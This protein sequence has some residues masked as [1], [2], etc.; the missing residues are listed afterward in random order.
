VSTG[1]APDWRDDALCRRSP[2]LQTFFPLGTTAPAR[3]TT[4]RAKTFCG[5][6]PV[7]Q[8][9]AQWALT[10]NMEFGVWGGLDEDERRSIR[11][12][13]RELLAN[14]KELWK[15]LEARRKT[16][17][18]EAL[19]DAYLSRTEQDDDGHVRWLST[20]TS[21]SVR[22]RVFTPAQMAFELG[23][24][25]RPESTVKVQCGRIGCVAAEHLADGAIRRQLAV[26]RK[27]AA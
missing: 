15:F 6:C 20:K 22:G 25:R 10:E 12:H 27:A 1:R 26:A 11:R 24:G 4:E 7:R 5:F 21:V 19:L 8:A 13:H 3:A 9:C 18:R 16:E 14:P 17:D 23:H 2:D